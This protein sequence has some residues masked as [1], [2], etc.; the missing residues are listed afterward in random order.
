[1]GTAILWGQIPQDSLLYQHAD[2]DPVR[3]P[4]CRVR[5][6][7]GWGT[8]QGRGTVARHVAIYTSHPRLSPTLSPIPR[9]GNEKDP[10]YP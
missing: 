8:G 10:T 6:G 3:I 1:M 5:A 9:R 2:H 4:R 7:D